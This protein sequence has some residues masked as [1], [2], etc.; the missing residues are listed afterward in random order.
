MS[1][2]REGMR[3][4]VV[5]AG[6]D[7]AERCSDEARRDARLAKVVGT[8]A[9]AHVV[10]EH[11][12]GVRP[13]STHLHPPIQ[14][15]LLQLFIGLVLFAHRLVHGLLDFLQDRLQVS[16][17]LARLQSAEFWLAGLRCFTCV[18]RAG[19]ITC[20]HAP[21]LRCCPRHREEAAQPAMQTWD[22]SSRSSCT[23][24]LR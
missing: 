21:Q 22:R 14:Q 10:D 16:L 20:C 6:C 2:A 15:Q 5:E 3:A 9:Q 12:T 7:L 17:T 8:P 24:A 13:P 11:T 1:H 18:P 4:R 19:S 23:R